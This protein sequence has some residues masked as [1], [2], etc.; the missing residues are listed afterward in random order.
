[1]K[2]LIK[3]LNQCFQ[4]GLSKNLEISRKGEWVLPDPDFL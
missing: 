4:Q 1:M 3:Y 2:H